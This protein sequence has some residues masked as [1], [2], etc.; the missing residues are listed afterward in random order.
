MTGHMRVE[1]AM[2][3]NRPLLSDELRRRVSLIQL[4]P[5]TAR[6]ENR[7]D[8]RH[9]DLLQWVAANRGK[10]IWAV[11]VLIK[12]WIDQGA[13]TP[14]HAPVIGSYEAYVDVIGG[15]LEAASPAWITWQANRDELSQIASDNEE[16]EI[17]SLLSAW[18]A[19]GGKPMEGVEL[20]ALAEAQKIVLPIARV[21]NGGEFEYK[22]RSMGQYLSGFAGRIFALESGEY[23][24][25]KSPVKGTGWY[26]W[27]LTKKQPAPQ[28]KKKG[29]RPQRQ[30]IKRD[31]V[32]PIGGALLKA[33]QS[34]ETIP[35]PWG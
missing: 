34:K 4:K 14:R 10:A 18:A 26:P 11:L 27:T 23:E 2:I 22:T 33:M 28:A 17:E 1:Y 20:C 8:F 29:L 16:S 19:T 12:N 24:L 6:P 7:S 15:I 35:N 13:W 5:D 25:A 30:L 32:Q 3:G 21:P 9:P 31:P